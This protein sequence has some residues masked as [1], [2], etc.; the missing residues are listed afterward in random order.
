MNKTLSLI[1][2]CFLLF[3][4]TEAWNWPT[5]KAIVQ[6]VYYSFPLELTQKLD[7]ELMEIGSIAP[8]KDF[9]D[10]RLHHYPPSYNKSQYWLDNLRNSLK[11]E[12]YENASY[13]F[14]V[15]T[16]YI[17]DSFVAPHNI[18][19]ENPSDHSKFEKQV[20]TILTKCKKNDYE[21]NNSLYIASQNDKDWEPW[22]NSKDSKIPQKELEQTM[23][24]IYSVALDEFNITCN[25]KTTEIIK[26]KYKLGSKTQTYLGTIL[27]LY[28]ILFRKKLK[29][30]KN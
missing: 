14:G 20:S 10:Q 21:L 23:K 17:S 2:L 11:E 16:H 3:P 4:S 29:R 7:L 12:D 27:I 25:T 1:I 24:L 19:G 8:D 9:H 28:L 13:A 26:Q 5:H 18:K 30:S 15:V 6:K 22:L